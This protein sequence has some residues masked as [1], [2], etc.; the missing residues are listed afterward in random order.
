M[1]LIA[2]KVNF[3]PALKAIPPAFPGAGFQRLAAK[4][5]QMS[6]DL[7]RG[8]FEYVREKMVNLRVDCW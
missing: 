5:R 1:L 6:E 2:R 8:P 3:F 7:I 4:W